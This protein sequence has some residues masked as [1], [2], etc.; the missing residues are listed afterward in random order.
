[1]MFLTRGL[2]RKVQ[3]KGKCW[4]GYKRDGGNYAYNKI[5][6]GTYREAADSLMK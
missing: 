3:K 4:F 5:V 2:V 1:M 6:G